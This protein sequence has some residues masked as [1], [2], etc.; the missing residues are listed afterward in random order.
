MRAASLTTANGQ[1]T[2]PAPIIATL[3]AMLDSFHNASP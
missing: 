2:L 1:T 3:I